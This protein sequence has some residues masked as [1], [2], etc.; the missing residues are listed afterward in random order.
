VR[1]LVT[2]PLHS[3]E[4]TAKRLREMGHEPILLPLSQPAHD[5]AAALQALAETEGA[6]VVTSAEA[7]RTISPLAERLGPHLSRPL[8]AVG[9]ATAEEAR[10]IGFESV[11]ASAGNGSELADLIAEKNPGRILYLAGSPRAETFERRAQELGFGI[12]IAE[13]YRMQPIIPDL[14]TLQK[15]L[16]KPQLD[17]ILFYSR[18]TAGNFFRIPNIESELKMMTDIRYLCLSESVAEALSASLR[19]KAAIASMPDE[20]SLLSLL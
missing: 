20:K 19:E 13:C 18:Q 1:V 17:A 3:G 2:R 7:I 6:I 8:F 9:D 12:K 16:A 10:A 14:E 5:A 11:H 15:A 4:R